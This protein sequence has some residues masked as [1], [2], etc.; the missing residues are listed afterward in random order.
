[1]TVNAPSNG[2]YTDFQGLSQL[3]QKAGADA[4]DALQEVGKHFEALFIQMMLQ[5]MR[6]ASPGDPLFGGKEE[7][8]Y[9]DLF[10][11]QL[12]MTM[13]SHGNLGLADIIVRQLQGNSKLQ[14]SA[15]KSTSQVPLQITPTAS[16]FKSQPNDVQNKNSYSSPSTFVKS[17]LPYARK[18]A[19]QLNVDPQVLIAQAALE[20][21]WG[22][23]I[24][25]HS[26][27]RSSNNLFGIKAGGDWKNETVS[28]QTL[29]FRDGVA[30]KERATF[31]SY[32]S[33]ASSFQDYV[34]F[35]QNNPRYREA[36][37]HAG[38]PQ[39]FSQALQ[40]SGY[41]TDPQYAVKIHNILSSDTLA[42][43]ISDLKVSAT[44]PIG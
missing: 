15:D 20:T 30:V 3:R 42:S 16:Q 39:L 36:L 5:S 7:E 25:H 1:M 32:D 13:A 19:E 6:E 28:V 10:D 9:R 8:L 26:N 43:A 17:I 41:A 24:S 29:E 40:E 4:P 11:K 34:Q 23:G 12:S 44:N 35:L 22:R 18:A 33:L 21:G 31:R 37:V 14:D 38:D 2:V 27:G